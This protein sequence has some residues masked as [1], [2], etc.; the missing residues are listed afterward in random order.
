MKKLETFRNSLGKPG[1][2]KKC[3]FLEHNTPSGYIMSTLKTP[4]LQSSPD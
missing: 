3:R 2:N 1:G 4:G